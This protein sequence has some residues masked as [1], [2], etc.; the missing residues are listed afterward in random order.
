MSMEPET[1][2]YAFDNEPKRSSTPAASAGY[3]Q[4]SA[5]EN[6]E[7]TRLGELRFGSASES[8]WRR[9]FALRRK[10]TGR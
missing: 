8:E 9:Y 1:G 3:Q 7:Y 5:A 6:A 10:V 2:L 4:L